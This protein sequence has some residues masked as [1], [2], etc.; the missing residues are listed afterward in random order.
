VEQDIRPVLTGAKM[1]TSTSAK[2]N[3]YSVLVLALNNGTEVR[4]MLDA[5]YAALLT[6]LLQLK[7]NK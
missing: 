2:G 4:V 7:E 6:T 5:A 1:V 3:S